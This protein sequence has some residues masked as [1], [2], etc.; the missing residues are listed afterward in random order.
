[1]VEKKHR[2]ILVQIVGEGGS[3]R[4]STNLF[5]KFLWIVL[6]LNEPKLVKDIEI[7]RKG[8]QNLPVIYFYVKLVLYSGEILLLNAMGLTKVLKKFIARPEYG[9]KI[10]DVQ[11]K[12][13]E[14]RWQKLS[15]S[16]GNIIHAVCCAENANRSS[17]RT[18]TKFIQCHF[19]CDS[20]T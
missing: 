12:V 5:S 9:G 6:L 16:Y 19:Y 3:C 1:M 13:A 7:A 20:Y 2:L 15:S 4:S 18:I 8:F 11:N 10:S 14:L 17:S